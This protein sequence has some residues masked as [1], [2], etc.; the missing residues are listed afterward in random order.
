MIGILSIDFDYFINA[1]SQARDMYFPKGSDEIPEN[2]LKSV[3]EERYLKYPELKKIGVI[4]D[5][6]FLKKFVKELKIP[7]ENFMKADS[8][9]YIKSII[10]KLPEKSQFKIV[11]IDFH[12][13]YYHYYRGN[14]YYNCG[15]WLRRVLE[16]RPDT[17]VKWIRREDSQIYC[18]DGI[19]PFEHTDDIKSVY[20]EK[21]D[22]IFLCKSPEWTPP[23]LNSKFEELCRTIEQDTIL[24]SNMFSSVS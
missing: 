20:N 6:H 21:F 15:N 2:K 14:D 1:S 3:W 23:H 11:N 17:K 7:K 22:Y 18:L 19:F 12:H 13:D 24:Y 10:E 8:H 16:E 4:D 5:F 9:K